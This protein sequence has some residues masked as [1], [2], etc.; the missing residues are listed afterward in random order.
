MESSIT[1]KSKLP[2]VGM[3][4]FSK[5]SVLASEHNALNLA[6]GFPGFDVHEPLKKLVNKYMKEGKNQY[7]PMP[8]LLALREEVASLVYDSYSAKYNPDTEITIVPGATAGLYAAI[9]AIIKE[10]DEVILFEPA[11]DAYSPV[12]TLNGGVP[13]HFKM[14]IGD[15]PIDWNSLKKLITRNTRMIV[16]NSPH[17]PTGITLSAQDMVELE[18]LTKNTDILILS[19]EVYEHII[20]DGL[21]HQSVTRFPGLVKR[22]IVVSSFGKTFHAT[23]WK[24][25]YVLAPE[26]ITE[27][28]RKVYQFMVFSCHTPTQFALADF[29]KD[30]SYIIGLSSFYQKKRDIFKEAVKGSKFK[31]LPCKGTYFQSL[32][33]RGISEMKDVEFADWLTIEKGLA[34]I[35]TSVF[36]KDGF[37][38]KVLRFC[39]AKE[40]EDLLKAAKILCKI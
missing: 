40:E 12:I 28:I 7:A 39:F 18:K 9:T 15:N 16:L 2:D 14:L 29:L 11:Y 22:S 19:D 3:N 17:N 34:S 32:S 5:M 37:D 30:R 38:D 24:M 26:F 36:Y 25:G 27:E 4:I 23:G 10:R 20:F 6:Q 35:P 13:K 21:E 1:L 33:Y 8:G 31:I